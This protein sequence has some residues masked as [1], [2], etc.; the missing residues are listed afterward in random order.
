MS[1]GP[2]P[3]TIAAIATPLG[4]GA[5]SLLRVSG[6][7]T[8]ELLHALAPDL[9]GT[10]PAPRR[11][12]LT[13]LVDPRSGALLDRG[14]A[15]WFPAPASYTGEDMMELSV[16]GGHLVARRILEVLEGMGAR[17]ARGGEFTQRAYLNGKVDLV[18][19]EAVGALVDAGTEAQRRV[20]LHAAEGGLS[21]RI[22]ELREGIVD[23][24]ALLVHHVDFPEEDEP[25]VPL[26]AILREAH[27][28]DERL[29]RLLA[30]APEGER[31]TAGALVVLAGPPNAGKSS[32]YNALVGEA[33]ALVSEEPGTTRDALEMLISMEGFPFRLVD[34]AGLR[35]DAGKVERMGIEVAHRYLKEADLIL[36][37]RE[38]GKGPSWEGLRREGVREGTPILLVNTKGDGCPEGDRGEAEGIWVSVVSGEGLAELRGAMVARAFE[39]LS[40]GMEEEVVLTRARQR[41]GVTRAR[42]GIRSFR[43]AVE[44]GIPVPVA[45]VELRDAWD[46]LG[47]VTGGIEGDEVLSRVFSRFCIGK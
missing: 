27:T 4:R 33:R 8:L 26:E 35:G 36:F 47:E 23:L 1:R 34:T 45:E 14:L 11:A 3:D 44:G 42:D 12:T 2:S 31:L 15:T 6:D 20:A 30:T 37:C 18:Q 10:L 21:R 29:N 16:H 39:G 40:G 25:P 43:Q 9:G 24:Q 28:L 38:E 41:E 7:G 13:R 17:Q 5:L 32:L 22:E 19:A 46:A